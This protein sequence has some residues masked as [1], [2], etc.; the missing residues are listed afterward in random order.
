M[1]KFSKSVMQANVIKIFDEIHES[2]ISLGKSIN[3]LN[4]N[5]IDSNSFT[6]TL[7]EIYKLRENITYEAQNSGESGKFDLSQLHE[8]LNEIQKSFMEVSVYAFLTDPSLEIGS[9]D[10]QDSI[11][12]RDFLRNASFMNKIPQNVKEAIENI[13]ILPLLPGLYIRGED[14][15][16]TFKESF[17]VSD[18]R[19]KEADMETE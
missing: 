17:F 6:L 13:P 1:L 14:G 18:V 15:S 7:K 9:S 3:T 11:N 2:S 4:Q 10:N 5:Q 16:I 12:K 8:K 19:V